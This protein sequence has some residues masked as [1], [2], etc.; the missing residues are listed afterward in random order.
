M[1][2]TAPRTDTSRLFVVERAGPHP[3]GRQRR[4]AT[5]PGPD[6]RAFP[7]TPASA[8]FL[9]WRSPRTTRPAAGSTCSTRREPARRRDGRGVPAQR[10]RSERCGPR[11]RTRRALDPARPQSRP[12]RRAAAVRAR[13][14]ALHQ[15][16]RCRRDRWRSRGQRAEPDVERH[17]RW[18]TAPIT[19]RCWGRSC[20]SIRAPARPTPFRPAIPSPPRL[21]RCMRTGCEI[22]GGSRSI[23]SRAT[24][25]SQTSGRSAYEEVDFAAVPIAGSARTSAGTVRG[26]AHLPG[27]GAGDTAVPGRIRVSRSSRSRIRG[28]GVCSI[29]GGYVVRDPALPE[30]AGQ[31]I[32]GDFCNPELRAVSLTGSGAQ[33]D[34]AIGLDVNFVTSFGEDACARVYVVSYSAA[35]SIA[36]RTERPAVAP[37]RCPRSRMRP[38]FPSAMSARLRATAVTRPRASSSASPAPRATPSQCAMRRRM[39]RRASPGTTRARAVS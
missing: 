32:Y 31:Y 1:F 13:R 39:D 11:L 27:R 2:V 16:G 8:G 38:A 28:D 30:L 4:E 3:G 19:I 17:R 24:S 15:R 9:R 7:R 37:S 34:H 33:N 22:R 6:R 25:S 14:R 18:S 20:G 35:R 23:G 10:D 21:V 12:Q 26:A 36:Y 29:T 5:V